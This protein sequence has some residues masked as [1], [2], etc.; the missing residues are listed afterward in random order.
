MYNQST[1]LNFKIKMKFAVTT[2]KYIEQSS[3]ESTTETPTIQLLPTPKGPL[4]IYGGYRTGNLSNGGATKVL[5]PYG[6]CVK[7]ITVPYGSQAKKVFVPYMKQMQLVIAYCSWGSG[8]AVSLPV[9]PGQC[10][11]GLLESFRVKVI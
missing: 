5:V 9:G 10:P 1:P 6:K 4:S 2:E 7:N 3:K 11:G 8:G